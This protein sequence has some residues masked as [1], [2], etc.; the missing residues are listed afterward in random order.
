MDDREEFCLHGF[1]DILPTAV[2]LRGEE[3]V[4]LVKEDDGLNATGIPVRNR[5]IGKEC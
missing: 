3:L 5:H 1:T 2:Y 4:T